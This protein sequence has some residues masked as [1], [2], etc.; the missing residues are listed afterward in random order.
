MSLFFSMGTI[1]ISNPLT[2]HKD[3][4]HINFFHMD[5]FSELGSS[6]VV[7]LFPCPRRGEPIKYCLGHMG[8]GALALRTAREGVQDS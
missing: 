1:V 5:F 8:D 4:K 2:H 7:F 6:L 3:A